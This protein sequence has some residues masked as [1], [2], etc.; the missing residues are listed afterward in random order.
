[1]E[2]EEEGGEEEEEEE[3]GGGGGEEDGSG[4]EEDA[5]DFYGVAD[6]SPVAQAKAAGKGTT[7]GKTNGKGAAGVKFAGSAEASES[8]SSIRSSRR[9]FSKEYQLKTKLGSGTYADVFVCDHRRTR[10]VCAVKVINLRKL[11]MQGVGLKQSTVDREIAILKQC[12][13][14]ALV[15]FQ[16]HFHSKEKKEVHI[17]M[18]IC[19]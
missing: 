6:S 13:H 7:N 11:K 9:A 18:E 16:D 19:P 10:K 14:S 2:E 17:V 3:E 1:V 8:A 5:V 12:H 4:Q 15:Q